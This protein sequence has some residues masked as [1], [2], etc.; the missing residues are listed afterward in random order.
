MVSSTIYTAITGRAAGSRASVVARARTAGSDRPLWLPGVRAPAHLDGKVLGDRGFD[1]LGLGTDPD[2]LKWYREAEL[3]NG[4]FAMIGALGIL[5]TEYAVPGK[6][7]E[8]G[9]ASYDLPIGPLIAIQAVVMGF[10]ETKR[11]IGFKKT[12]ECGLVNTFPWD[13]LG[14]GAQDENM[15][16]KEL[17][18]SATTTATSASHHAFCRTKE[19]NDEDADDEFAPPPRGIKRR[20]ALRTRDWPWLPCSVSSCRPL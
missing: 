6:W 17:K 9:A 11:Y 20:P 12:G 7:Y 3:M 2:R 4:R 8:R 16:L 18:V 10:L 5:A 1:P 19:A 13:P 14:Y 15:K